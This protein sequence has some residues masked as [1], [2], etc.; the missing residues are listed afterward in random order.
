MI[1]CAKSKYSLVV[2][3]LLLLPIVA[4][5]AATL[6]A[7]TNREGPVTVKVT[8]KNTSSEAKTWDF[9]IILDTHTASL[10]QDMKRAAVL[11][12][13]SGKP[14]PPLA[15]EGDP[16]GGHH[17]K[18]LLRFQPLAGSPAFLE[19]RINGIGGVEQRVFRW[20]LTE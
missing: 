17:R 19:V 5:Q 2:A 6:Q 15:W 9:E 3:V 1:T 13:G 18:G 7:Q 12:D 14:Q 4:A 8:P 10:D 11:V 16:P 20:R